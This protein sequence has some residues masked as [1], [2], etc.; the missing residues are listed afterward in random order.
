MTVPGLLDNLASS[1]L[2]PV[3]KATALREFRVL[4]TALH[5]SSSYREAVSS[6]LDCRRWCCHWSVFSSGADSTLPRQPRVPLRVLAMSVGLSRI[7][8]FL[9]EPVSVRRWLLIPYDAA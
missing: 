7:L 5:S 2:E 4:H 9:K 6:S 1:P 3:D 8:S